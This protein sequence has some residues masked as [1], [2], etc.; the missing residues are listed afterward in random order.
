MYRTAANIKTYKEIFSKILCFTLSV[1][2]I[3]I[4]PS[5]NQIK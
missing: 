2:L 4:A 1:H 3:F 5:D